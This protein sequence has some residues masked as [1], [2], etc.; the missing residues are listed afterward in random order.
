MRKKDFIKYR[1]KTSTFKKKSEETSNHKKD[2]GDT[3]QK[4]LKHIDTIDNVR[5]ANDET[6][7]DMHNLNDRFRK[8]LNKHKELNKNKE[9]EDIRKKYQE[10]DEEYERRMGA[11]DRRE[12]EFNERMKKERDEEEAKYKKDRKRWNDRVNNI[13]KRDTSPYDH[14]DTRSKNN[15][16]SDNTNGPLM[17][18]FV[19]IIRKYDL[20]DLMDAADAVDGVTLEAKK[21]YRHIT[22]NAISAENIE[23][24]DP[25]TYSYRFRELKPSKY[26]YN[27]NYFVTPSKTGKSSFENDFGKLQN[28]IELFKKIDF[29]NLDDKVNSVVQSELTKLSQFVTKV[30]TDISRESSKF[31]QAQT[32]MS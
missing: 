7:K 25:D 27:F 19:Q 14:Y 17:T 2:Y 8:N 6:I 10:Y 22:K 20:K 4:I 5:K 28:I 30:T 12:K 15:T 11:I 13:K 16:E 24:I 21:L 26:M 18:K 29:S 31:L 23:P 1:F 32:E 3:H 9:Y